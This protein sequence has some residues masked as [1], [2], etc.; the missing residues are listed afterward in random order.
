MNEVAGSEPCTYLPT[1]R[2]MLQTGVAACVASA[3]PTAVSALAWNIADGRPHPA[4]RKFTSPVIESVIS[5]LRQEISDP[6]LGRIFE[7][8]FPNTLDTTVFPGTFAGH[9]DTFVITGDINAMWLRD[10][11]AQVWPYVPFARQDK[12][13]AALIEG[14]VRR[15]ARLILIDAYA[16][17][18]TRTTSDP[19]LPWATHDQTEMR[20]GV[21]ERK[22]E[23]DSLCY[24]VRLAGC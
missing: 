10:S 2:T 21:A 4:D 17:A 12:H 20:L 19:P 24:T 8:C 5:K 11:S 1:R 16:N 9:P 3:L 15:Q 7:H 22:W 18:F 14:V 23:V 6:V 13:L